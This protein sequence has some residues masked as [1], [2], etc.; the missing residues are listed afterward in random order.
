MTDFLDLPG[1]PPSRRQRGDQSVLFN[2]GI[3]DRRRIDLWAIAYA[4]DT[5]VV[6][7]QGQLRPCG[8]CDGA[9]IDDMDGDGFAAARAVT[10]VLPL[11]AE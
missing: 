7:A 8:L 5:V 1:S 4:A 2:C 6:C 11:A 10:P 9:Y 3:C